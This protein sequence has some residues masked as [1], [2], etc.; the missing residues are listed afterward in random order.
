MKYT[1]LHGGRSH[2]LELTPNVSGYLAIYNGEMHEIKL[3]R[4]EANR[5]AFEIGERRVNLHI[6]VD[7]NFRWIAYNGG[8]YSLQKLIR[9]SRALRPGEPRPEGALRS[10]MPGQ[11]RA[12][13]VVENEAVTKGQTLLLL[14]AMKMEIRV[15]APC[16]GVIGKIIVEVGDT[17][18]KDQMLVEIC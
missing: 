1:Y 2:T 7:K 10:P 9:S 18:Q 15:L 5:I 11:V 8:I 6:A 16:D 12:V 4:I 13:Q 3:L 17:V 14:E